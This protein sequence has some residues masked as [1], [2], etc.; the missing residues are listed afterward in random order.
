MAGREARCKQAKHT[1][2]GRGWPQ[3]LRIKQRLL[4]FVSKTEE[5]K[6]GIFGQNPVN[7]D[8]GS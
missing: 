5:Y 7:L 1:V 3:D 6:K 4:F 2:S 8:G